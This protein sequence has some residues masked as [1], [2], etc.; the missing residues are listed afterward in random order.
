[1]STEPRLTQVQHWVQE[2]IVDPADDE[3]VAGANGEAAERMVL[4][5]RTLSPVER[6]GIY[7][8]MYL[9]RMNEAIQADFPALEHFLGHE[10]FEALVKGYVQQFPSR[11][12]TLSRL[13]EHLPEY[14]ASTS[15]IAKQ[16]FAH[17]LARL[18]RAMCEVFDAP[19]SPRLD[20][21]AFARTQSAS[22]VETDY[23]TET[24]S[25]A[26]EMAN[27]APEVDWENVRLR[28]IE[29][30]RVLSLRYPVNEYLQSVKDESPHPVARRK[31]TWL[32]VY[33]RDYTVWRLPL[34][35]PAFNM[36]EALTQG[37]SLGDALRAASRRG[38]PLEPHV[39]K[40]FHTWV[41]EGIFSAIEP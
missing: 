4:P 29:A 2:F 23:V 35:K 22:R 19:E 1:M 21:Q 20:P 14:I 33:R 18:E 36:L 25:G 7:R 15:G 40:W 27:A 26:T 30:L 34:S 28:P 16:A 24:P 13:R 8:G 11:S 37:R 9:L 39:F 17:D 12:F 10:P 3:A 41:A 6:V 31:E 38:A 32:A 5:S